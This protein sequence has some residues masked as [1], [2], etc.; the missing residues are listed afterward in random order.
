LRIGIAFDLAPAGPGEFGPDDQF[1]EF[2]KPETVEAIADVLRRRGHDILLLGDG[3]AFLRRVLDEPPDLVWNIAEGQ[4]IGRCREARVPAV[5]EML[6]IPYTGSDPLTL[7]ATLDKNVAQRLMIADGGQVRCPPSRLLPPG[8]GRDQF[9]DALG[10][11]LNQ[12]GRRVI[13]KPG[14]E[15]SSKGIRGD[16]LATSAAE[17]W[18]IYHRLVDTYRQPAIAECFI[19]GEEVTVGLVG[20]GG[21][22]A[23][24]VLG[25]MQIVP[26]Q[27]DPLFVYSLDMK[28]NW[29]RCIVYEAPAKLDP[30]VRANLFT[31]A[32]HAYAVL[33]CRD[34]ARIDFRIRDGIPF[35]IEAN[36]LPGLAPE[37]SD[38]VILA[39][40]HGLGYDE[41]IGRIFEAALARLGL[42]EN[43]S[44][45]TTTL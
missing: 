11:L 17:A 9:N 43:G 44:E 1:E 23:V 35:F 20:N 37:T 19:E 16:C 2:D 36:P 38:L 29:R 42:D 10:P 31:A 21:P 32:C 45:T 40:G 13:L 14:F 24:E 25:A 41:L 33:G 8:L 3:T 26:R 15:G 18:P 7:A 12:E 30:Q 22:G 5:L 34:V 27:P 6:G 28:R 39:Q 4:G